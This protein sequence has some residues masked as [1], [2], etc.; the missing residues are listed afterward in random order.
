VGGIDLDILQK[1]ENYELKPDGAARS[2]LRL[3]AKD[4]EGTA[5]ALAPTPRAE[6]A[7]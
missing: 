5:R 4:P 3:I 1:L 6:A 2:L 7:E